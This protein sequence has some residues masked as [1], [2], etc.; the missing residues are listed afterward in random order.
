M[1][2]LI[3]TLL[4]CGLAYGVASS[5]TLTIKYTPGIVLDAS[6]EEDAWTNIGWNNAELT[7]TDQ[8]AKKNNTAKFK[9]AYDK[10]FLWVYAEILDNT[11]DTSSGTKATETWLKDCVE[12]FVALDTLGQKYT[13]GANGTFQSRKVFGRDLGNDGSSVT[14]GIRCEESDIVGGKAQEWQFPWDS[15]ASTLKDATKWDKKNLRFEFQNGDNDGNGRESQLF[16]NSAADDQWSTTAN[17]GFLVTEWKV[18][19]K[20]VTNDNGL[21]FVENVIK[22]DNLSTIKVYSMSGALIKI[23]SNVNRLSVADLK[24]GIYAATADNKTIKFYKK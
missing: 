24:S 18:G 19:I 20:N 17:E 13:N 23:A 1:K 5:K 10:D 21:R 4:A 15:V 9:V 7:K 3:F 16:W 14:K 22:V 11:I 2:R 6:G 12:V 8:V